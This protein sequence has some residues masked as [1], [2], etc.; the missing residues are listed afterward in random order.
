MSSTKNNEILADETIIRIIAA[1]V[2]LIGI[3]NL[4]VHSYILSLVLCYDFL[5]RL[6][7]LGK[8]SPL[9]ILSATISKSLKLPKKFIYAAPKRFAALVGFIFS[10]A[11]TLTLI[12]NLNFLF[13][14]LSS[15]LIVCAVLESVFSICVA[16]YLY[17]FINQ[18]K[19][20]K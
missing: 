11:I 10:I 3:T 19:F 20:S 6:S 5:I 8:Y 4:F 14:T 7:A 16:C 17:S 15:T 9:K 12:F 13:Y 2:T 1:F 18:L